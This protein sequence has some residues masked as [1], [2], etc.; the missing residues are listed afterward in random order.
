VRQRLIAPVCCLSV[1]VTQQAV[2]FLLFLFP[3]FRRLCFPTVLRRTLPSPSKLSHR[4]KSATAIYSAVEQVQ[5]ARKG[6]E[7]EKEREVRNWRVECS[8]KLVAHTS[9]SSLPRLLFTRHC[10][11]DPLRRLSDPLP[12]RPQRRSRPFTRFAF[13]RPR[14]LLRLV[15]CPSRR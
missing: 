4:R 10:R 7:F 2:P 15:Q 11:L 13:S 9:S 14:A 1:L 3:H 6:D 8:E 5:R 12:P